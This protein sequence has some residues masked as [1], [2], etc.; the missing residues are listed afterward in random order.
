LSFYSSISDIFSGGIFACTYQILK[1]NPEYRSNGKQACGLDDE[2][3]IGIDKVQNNPLEIEC[4]YKAAS[5]YDKFKSEYI[6]A[7]AKFDER[8]KEDKMRLRAQ[9]QNEDKPVVNN[10][11]RY[12]KG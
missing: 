1:E 12:R 6:N 2:R 11:K 3:W 4:Y 8:V 10:G 7:F 9:Q 5:I